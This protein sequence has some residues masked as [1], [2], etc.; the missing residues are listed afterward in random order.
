MKVLSIVSMFTLAAWFAPSLCFAS[1]YGPAT[2]EQPINLGPKSDPGRIPLG[3]VAVVCNYD[4]GLHANIGASRPCPDGAMRWESGTELDQNL[5]SVFGISLEVK[6]PTQ[7]RE[8]PV[9]L[10]IKSWKPPSYSPYTK[11][12]VL[13]AT[14]WCLVR[15]AG[16]TPEKPLVVQ[17]V[18]DGQDDKPLEAK[19]SGK[20]ITRSGSDQKP[21]PPV[22]VSGTRIEEDARGIA[23]VVFSD[24]TPKAPSRQPPPVLTILQTGGGSD[25][26]WYL[27]PE[28]RKEID[29]DGAKSHSISINFPRVG[30]ETLAAQI[31]A[32]VISAQPTESLPLTVSFRLEEYGLADYPAFRRAAGWKETRHDAHN[33]TLECEFVWD[34]TSRKLTQGTLPFVELDASGRFINWRPEA[35][36]KDSHAKELADVVRSRISNGIHDG[37]LLAEKNMAHDM[38]A[39]SGLRR[40]I[41]L[42]GYYEALATFYKEGEVTDKPVKHT[43]QF[44]NSEFD[45]LH[46]MGWTIGMN[47]GQ[48]I[49]IEARKNIE[50][51][52]RKKAE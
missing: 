7:I 10:R 23:W 2:I 19:Y 48:A 45:Q 40:Q 15:G 46:H 21:A 16:G 26:G 43:F 49:V 20:F 31:L 9:I 27:I 41:G 44:E 50:E 33:I 52:K 25:S 5:A 12:Q 18:A 14:L 38:L 30:Q 34:A 11:D 4:Y 6:D 39:D 32:L 8:F 36:P 3:S 13:A 35:D 47:R 29:D 17:V 28:W 22:Q 51:A 24:V 37:S 42:A 1:S